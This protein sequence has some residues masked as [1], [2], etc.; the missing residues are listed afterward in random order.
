MVRS[1]QNNLHGSSTP[2]N[3]HE[4]TP[5]QPVAVTDEQAHVPGPESFVSDLS[6]ELLSASDVLSISAQ[7]NAPIPGTLF[8]GAFSNTP[9][10]TQ[11]DG[12][13]TIPTP[14]AE[15]SQP[16]SPILAHHLHHR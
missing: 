10:I 5:P 1:V 11:H 13:S 6:T 12:F 2:T 15:V 14:T 8:A 4:Q 3:T 9:P 16:S 7:Q